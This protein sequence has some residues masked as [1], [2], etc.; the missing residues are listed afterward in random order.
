MHR[1][2][3]AGLLL[4]AALVLACWAWAAEAPLAHAAPVPSWMHV[5][6]A[7]K[8]VSFTVIAAQG[9]A[10]G[11]LNFNGYAAGNLTVTVPVGWGVHIDFTNSGAGALPHSL[12]VIR[13]PSKM[14]PQGIAPAIPEA[15]TRNLVEG[16]PPQQGDTVDFTAAPAGQY[17]WFCGV[18]SHGLSGMW[19]RFIVSSSVSRPT[20]TTK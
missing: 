3:C 5:D 13:A 15:E 14:P 1:V 2:S 11:T 17:L 20:V 16:I 18:P 12:E 7:H 10:N 9:G 6:A 8:R 19:T 4:R